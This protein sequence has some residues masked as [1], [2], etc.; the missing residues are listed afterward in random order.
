MGQLARRL[1]TLSPPHAGPRLRGPTRSKHTASMPIAILG[2]YLC[3]F[4]DNDDNIMII[5][6]RHGQAPGSL[7]V[8]TGQACFRQSHLATWKEQL[9]STVE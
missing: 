7:A 6:I 3:P 4:V 9:D 1:V 8:P 5:R 2:F